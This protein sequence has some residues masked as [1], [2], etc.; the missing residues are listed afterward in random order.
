LQVA[1]WFQVAAA[2]LMTAVLLIALRDDA[3]CTVPNRQDKAE[4][5]WPMFGGSPG[6]NMVNANERDLPADWC[7]EEGKRKNIQWVAEL[8]N[9]TN[10]SPVV[11]GGKVF[12]ATNKAKSRDK[13]V[14]MAFRESD[15]R[16]LWQIAHDVP[17]R[18]HG[19]SGAL[20]STPSV[21]GGYLYYVTSVG[22][23]ICADADRGRIQ[24][25]YDMVKELKV[26]MFQE[27]CPARNACPFWSSPLVIGDLVFAATGNGIDVD[28]NLVAPNAPSF[29]ALD[30]RT[31]KLVWQSNLPGANIIQGEFASP[32]FADHGGRPQVVFAGGD[33]VIYSFVP[34][35]GALLWKCDCLP[36]RKKKGAAGIDHQFVGTPVVVGDK[37]FVGMGNAVDTPGNQRKGCYFLCLDI[38]K[39]GD[40]SLKSY[41][42]KAAVNKGSALVWAFGGLV[43]PRPERGRK[44]HFGPTTSTAAVHEG[45]VYIT[46]ETGYLHCLDAATGSR[47]W[48]YDT[49]TALLGSPY[50]VDGRVYV[51]TDDGEV[52]IFAHDRAARIRATIDMDEAMM[53]TTPVA[54]NGRLY[55][56]TRSK[57]YAIGSR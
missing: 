10:G 57:L 19:S 49:W 14:M 25:R 24:W 7:V 2:L 12:V 53:R 28:G 26:H 22:E 21:V 33:G 50:L 27:F 5:S 55:V 30:K 29:I 18:Y 35:T 23:F 31:G 38:T 54:A 52:L 1:R 3:A 11:A 17:E 40:I 34:E 48:V 32:T 39:K 13:A 15:G 41:D 47:L 42:A 8:G 43:E 20:P 6:R 45:L 36:E 37:L 16:P 4:H 44:I 51:A 46:E 9:Q 56:A